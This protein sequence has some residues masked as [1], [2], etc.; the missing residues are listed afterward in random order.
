MKIR[1]IGG[2][3]MKKVLVLSAIAIT[4]FASSTQVFAAN[5]VS[6]MATTNGGQHVAD[7]AQKMDK[8]V[9]ECAKLVECEK[10]M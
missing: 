4:L 3:G 7:C 10:G 6:D 8:G 1:D 2:I 9:S 5:L